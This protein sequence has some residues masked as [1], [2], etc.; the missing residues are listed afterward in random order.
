MTLHNILAHKEIEHWAEEYECLTLYLNERNVPTKNEKELS[1]VGR[2]EE[3]VVMRLA[4][5][6]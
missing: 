3:Y 6:I 5:G 4:N 2:I 1:L